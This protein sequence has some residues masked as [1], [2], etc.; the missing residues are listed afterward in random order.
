MR[1]RRDFILCSL[2][3]V[4]AAG[5]NL[6]Q[7]APQQ[8]DVAVRQRKQPELPAIGSIPSI[9][10]QQVMGKQIEKSELWNL[11]TVGGGPLPPLKELFKALYTINKSGRFEALVR[12]DRPADRWEFQGVVTTPLGLQ[13]VF[14][15]PA[16]AGKK[17]RLLSTGQKIDDRLVVKELTARSVTVTDTADR[18]K[19]V[20]FTLH[21]FNSN[22]EQYAKKTNTR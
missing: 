15:N 17:Y 5:Y 7:H 4:L 16:I 3:V 22:R 11:Q 21:I 12:S 1:V 6:Y 13:A 18:K 19:P 8:D 9:A 14:Y 2:A 10:P 20:N